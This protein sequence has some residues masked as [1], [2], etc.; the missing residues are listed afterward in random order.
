MS[1]CGAEKV[2]FLSHDLF[3]GAE[4]SLNTLLFQFYLNTNKLFLLNEFQTGPKKRPEASHVCC[5]KCS[6]VCLKFNILSPPPHNTSLSFSFSR[7][8]SL[9]LRLSFTLLFS[10]KSLLLSFSSFSSFSFITA[11]FCM[12]DTRSKMSVCRWEVEEII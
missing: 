6:Y 1:C 7:S 12:P 11:S 3:F 9:S 2:S 4:K 5:V 8:T 10:F